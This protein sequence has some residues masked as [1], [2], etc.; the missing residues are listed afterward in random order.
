[1]LT[2]GFEHEAM[3]EARPANYC[4][5]NNQKKREDDLRMIRLLEGA[6][7]LD[8]LRDAL[9]GRMAADD[10]GALY[11]CV[12]TG[13]LRYRNR[14]VSILSLFKG[15]SPRNISGCLFIPLSSVRTYLRAYHG[16]GIGPFLTDQR[17]KP[18]KH[19]NPEYVEKVFSILHSP[20]SLYGLN[21][22][23]WTQDQ[24][25]R[26]MKDSGMP[27]GQSGIKKIIDKSG[28]K[29]QKARIVLTSH[30]PR[31]KEKVGEIKNVLANLGPREKFFSIDEFGPFAVKLQGGRSLVPAG[32][33]RIVPQW[34]KSKGS[35]IITAALELSTNQITH[36]YSKKK[37]TL[38]MIRLLDLLL[39][40]HLRR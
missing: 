24:I 32:T 17:S 39:A 33:T 3:A 7:E 31:Y 22:T 14:A 27:I 23:S 11:R 5:M 29:Y 6:I 19:E 21:R 34:Q 15:I 10:I 37:N 4:R 8:E 12:T 36:F 28:F 1:M 30:D 13:P 16:K 20:P 35:V 38:E 2:I 18:H 26:M 25:W 9:N 40:G